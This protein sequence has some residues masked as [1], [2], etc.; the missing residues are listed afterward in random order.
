MSDE[1]K[2]VSGIIRRLSRET[3]FKPALLIARRSSLIAS[4]TLSKL[5]KVAGK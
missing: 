3:R 4:H 2:W 5:P 1:A